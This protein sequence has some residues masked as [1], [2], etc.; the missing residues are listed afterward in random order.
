MR[1]AIVETPFR[2][3]TAAEGERRYVAPTLDARRDAIARLRLPLAV[4]TPA[5]QLALF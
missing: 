2:A 5:A 4:V 1:T 3:A